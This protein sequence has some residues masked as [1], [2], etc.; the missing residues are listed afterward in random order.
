MSE[1][2]RRPSRIAI[3]GFL[4]TCTGALIDGMSLVGPVP[5]PILLVG[6]ASFVIGLLLLIPFGFKR[7]REEGR[8]VVR[9][10]GRTALDVLYFIFDVFP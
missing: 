3:S 6:L 1:E 4:L 8:G 10:I 9:S 5:K 2:R 7:R